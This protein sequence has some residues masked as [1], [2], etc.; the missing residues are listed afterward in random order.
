MVV[1]TAEAWTLKAVP[2]ADVILA[3]K[4]RHGTRA[5]PTKIY[6]ISGLCPGHYH[7]ILQREDG[8]H[9]RDPSVNQACQLQPVLPSPAGLLLLGKKM[10]PRNPNWKPDSY[11][12]TQ[13]PIF[14]YYFILDLH[15][16]HSQLQ[17][18][19]FGQGAR[20]EEGGK[21]EAGEWEGVLHDRLG[22]PLGSLGEGRCRARSRLDRSAISWL[23]AGLPW[24]F[25]AH[26][27]NRSSS[28][29]WQV[30]A[31]PHPGECSSVTSDSCSHICLQEALL[32]QKHLTSGRHRGSD[33]ARSRRG[34]EPGTGP[35]LRLS[36]DLF[37]PMEYESNTSRSFK[38]VCVF[39]L[40][41]LSFTG[42]E[43]S[44]S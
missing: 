40:H 35:I 3:V 14:G 26:V 36:C 19:G 9:L 15:S 6:M 5:Y 17:T 29:Q 10:S 13:N 18:V 4:L 28:H 38:W 37:W 33:S 16:I 39:W 25:L 30:P 34:E 23:L 8:L 27:G 2:A 32:E 21:R 7:L 11:Q 20:K 43:E 22:P 12:G 41:L 1:Y 42:H 31:G 44:L 24:A